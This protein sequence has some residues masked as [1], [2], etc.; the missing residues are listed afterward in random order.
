MDRRDFLGAAT[1]ASVGAA[2]G[3]NVLGQ[4][5]A[6]R[7]L[8]EATV[9]ELSAMMQKGQITSLLILSSGLGRST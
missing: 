6:A 1:L 5:A 3:S 2:L 9:A 4:R 7:S 8:E